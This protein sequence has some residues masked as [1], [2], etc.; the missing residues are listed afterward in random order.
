M[1]GGAGLVANDLPVADARLRAHLTMHPKDVAALRMRAEVAARLARYGDARD[2]LERCLELAPSLDAGRHNY[3]IVLN[4]Q[5]K[6]AEALAQVERLRVKDPRDP[7]YRNLQAAILAQIGDFAESIQV[8]ETA[9]REHPQQ[10]KIWMSYGHALKTARRQN[11]S[12]AAYRRAIAMQPTL[13]EA[14]WS[15]ANLKTFRFAEAD[16]VA[17]RRALVRNDL[18]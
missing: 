9:L 12:V 3:A 1:E 10:P 6:A 5:S 7:G 8:Y 14:Y 15:L 16:V 13:G 17:I 11:D 2:L 4:R 18:I